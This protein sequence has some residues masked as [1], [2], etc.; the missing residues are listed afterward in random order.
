MI[1]LS[2]YCPS[3]LDCRMGVNIKEKM[4]ILFSIMI[5]ACDEYNYKGEP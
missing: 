3:A 2:N 4:F 5:S 1:I